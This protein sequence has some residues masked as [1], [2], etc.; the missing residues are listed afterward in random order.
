MFGVLL[1]VEVLLFA[2]L[3]E[4]LEEELIVSIECAEACF[5]T[6]GENAQLVECKNVRDVLAVRQEV[7]VVCLFHLDC[8]VLQLDEHDRQSVDEK[9]NIRA[10]IVVMAAN[11]HLAHDRKDVIRRA[12][13]VDK[14]DK[15][16]VL[17]VALAGLYLDAVADA[18]VEAVVDVRHVLAG[19]VAAK[20]GVDAVDFLAVDARV[21][22]FQG[23]AEDF[24]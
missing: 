12:V 19:E 18:V 5:K 9:E 7:L 8:R 22:A 16:E 6:V 10:A 14:A 21:E 4:P 1:A 20:V 2:I 13:E 3:P 23:C 11:P 15:V 17:L 24:W